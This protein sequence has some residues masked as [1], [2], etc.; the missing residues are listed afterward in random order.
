MPFQEVKDTKIVSLF[1][2]P[3]VIDSVQG[4]NYGSNYFGSVSYEQNGST[5]FLSKKYAV[6]KVDYT[7]AGEQNA[8]K[9]SDGTDYL[10]PITCGPDGKL[11]GL[12]EAISLATDKALEAINDPTKG[13]A[14]NIGKIKS[15]VSGA[16]DEINSKISD[17][18]K[19]ESEVAQ[20]MQK[21]F[22]D[23]SKKLND[24]EFGK[25]LS[26]GIKSAGDK[27][28]QFL[29]GSIDGAAAAG[30]NLSG[31]IS[32]AL[33]NIDTNAIQSG[34]SNDIGKAQNFLSGSGDGSLTGEL[35]KAFG[36]NIGE[37]GS[38]SNSL[39]GGT[40]NL[41]GIKIPSVSNTEILSKYNASKQ[42][43]IAEFEKIWSP[44]LGK[45]DTSVDKLMGV[46]ND[47][48]NTLEICKLCPNVDLVESG[49]DASGLPIFKDI[50]KGI[51]LT[52]PETDAV[53]E[54][55]QVD[56]IPKDSVKIIT[57]IKPEQGEV[58][59]IVKKESTAT[60]LNN[61]TEKNKIIVKKAPVVTTPSADKK[62]EIPFTKRIYIVRDALAGNEITFTVSISPVNGDFIWYGSMTGIR[63]PA[64]SGMT[65][66]GYL[67]PG[68]GLPEAAPEF[69][70]KYTEKWKEKQ[71]GLIKSIQSEISDLKESSMPEVKKSPSL[72][73]NARVA[74][75]QGEL[76]L[77]KE[78]AERMFEGLPLKHQ[79]TKTK[80]YKQYK[81][82]SSKLQARQNQLSINPIIVFTPVIKS[83]GQF[84]QEAEEDD[85]DV[86]NALEELIET[87]ERRIK[88]V[89]K[90]NGLKSELTNEDDVESE[91]KELKRQLRDAK[92]LK[93]NYPFGE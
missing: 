22:E 26:D 6:V 32:A 31:S 81:A 72:S 59:S 44:A 16:L 86:M 75:L 12:E 55:T 67:K 3:I 71:D 60:V 27:L 57:K 74:K 93:P 76:T 39:T 19:P 64:T 24:P 52:V 7:T 77:F 4:K 56:I 69:W 45:T 1:Q 8:P 73:K 65:D 43:A 9:K 87:Y 63:G 15:E 47:P 58:A 41:A 25:E 78:D 36:S 80:L 35:S 54:K 79:T 50:I 18:A 84:W 70:R 61:A 29:G 49:K 90:I 20:N 14:A 17:L 10:P 92:E 2:E 68:V 11:Q 83:E 62:E 30:S 23:L 5:L 89:R 46:L 66:Q 28:S 37:L 53:K 85:T 21:D 34:L 51:P 13:I 91:I 42:K 48:T 40:N 82:S 33:G 88:Y 38:I